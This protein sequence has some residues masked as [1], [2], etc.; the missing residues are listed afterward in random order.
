M[1]EQPAGEHA[2]LRHKIQQLILLRETG[3]KK[4]AWHVART[5][6][7]WRLHQRLHATT[8]QEAS[9]NTSDEQAPARDVAP[10]S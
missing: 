6:L 7:L 2:R 1:D 10:G 4:A 3:P 9:T 8:Q 5:R